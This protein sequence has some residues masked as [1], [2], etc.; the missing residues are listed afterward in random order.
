MLATHLV[1][2][3]DYRCEDLVTLFNRTFMADYHTELV[4]GGAEPLYQPASKGNSARIIFTRDYFSS[5]LHEISHWLIAGSERR[6]LEDYGYWYCPDGR[7]A[8]QQAAFEQVEI[9]PQALEWILTK[10][11]GRSFRLSLD[12]LN[13]EAGDGLA[14]AQAVYKR[15]GYLVQQGLSVRA[16]A[17]RLALAEHYGGSKTLLA[18]DF[19]LQELVR[20]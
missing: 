9:A 5:A 17:M 1:T 13:G 12:N 10:A 6:K 11:C 18:E 16:E 14:F 8:Q 2:P 7:N 19:T 3:V 20:S 4:A 15:V